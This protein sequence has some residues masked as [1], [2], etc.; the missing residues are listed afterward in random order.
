MIF[1]NAA[2]KDAPKVAPSAAQ[3]QINAAQIDSDAFNLLLAFMNAGSKE[4][5]GSTADLGNELSSASGAAE[6]DDKLLITDCP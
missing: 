5:A 4:S 2:Q 3:V 1:V 6:G